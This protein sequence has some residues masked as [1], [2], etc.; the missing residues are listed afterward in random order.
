MGAIIKVAGCFKLH[1]A[2]RLDKSHPRIL[3][4]LSDVDVEL[5]SVILQNHRE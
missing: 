4:E 3:R 2:S 5:L 1:Q